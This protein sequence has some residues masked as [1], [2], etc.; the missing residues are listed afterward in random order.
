ML[1]SVQSKLCAG[2]TWW[3]AAASVGLEEPGY[4]MG[5]G[6]RHG[7]G[8]TGETNGTKA[9]VT[10]ANPTRATIE[11]QRRARRIETTS[12]AS[13]GGRAL[14]T[15]GLS[16]RRHPVSV[17]QQILALANLL[18]APARGCRG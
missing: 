11:Q 5:N 4:R 16:F 13:L 6:T 17:T 18:P 12:T 10:L 3:A 7:L 8:A 1:P 9:A 14:T 15:S 2:D